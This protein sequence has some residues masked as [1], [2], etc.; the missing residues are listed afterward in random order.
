MPCWPV[1][2]ASILISEFLAPYNLH[3]RHAD[4]IFA[5]PQGVHLF[6]DGRFVGPSR[7]WVSTI[8][9]NMQTL[10]REYEPDT[11]RIEKLRFFCKGDPYRWWGLVKGDLHLV[12]SGF[13]MARPFSSAPTGLAA[14]CFH[15]S[16]YG[17]RISLTVGLVRITFSFVLGIV[18]GGLAGYYGGLGRQPHSA[19][20]RSAP[21]IPGVAAVDGAIGDPARDLE[22]NP[23]LLRH[24]PD[25][26]AFSIGP[27]WRGR[28]A[29]SC[30]PYAKRISAR[31]RS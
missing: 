17:A 22:P 2:Y 16:S 31:P 3:S 21:L 27:G 1:L 29:R 6:D 18:I 9:L 23:D 19:H 11:S 30:L 28:C 14:T 25:F 24:H 20:N 7:L 12:L 13:S 5:P 26:W 10:E 8:V 4:F 15:A